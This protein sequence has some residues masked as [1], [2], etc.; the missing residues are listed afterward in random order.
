MSITTNSK[1]SIGVIIALIPLIAGAVVWY[2][3][4]KQDEHVAIETAAEED[5]AVV[6]QVAYVQNREVEIELIDAKLKMYRMLRE[7]RALT[8]DELADEEWLKERKRI[9][10]N[11]KRQRSS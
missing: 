2:D 5:R 3:E 11:E 8:P 4:R 9:L 10:L 6:A 7:H 1:I